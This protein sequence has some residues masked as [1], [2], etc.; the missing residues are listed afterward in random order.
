MEE[1]VVAKVAKW[2][3][4]VNHILLE[5]VVNSTILV[6]IAVTVARRR[7]TD[8]EKDVSFRD[9]VFDRF[10]PVVRSMVVVMFWLNPM[11]PRWF[12]RKELKLA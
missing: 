10:A 8:T 11:S 4:V 2:P 6:A 1:V 5:S 9:E 7:F 12:S 3:F